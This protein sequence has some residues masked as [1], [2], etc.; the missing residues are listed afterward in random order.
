MLIGK[1]V[2]L[3]NFINKLTLKVNTNSRL[4][5]YLQVSVSKSFVK[6][7]DN[8]SGISDGLEEG[9]MSYLSDAV[10]YSA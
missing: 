7:S 8:H 10:H 4:L 2:A 1:S 3:V 5:L 9:S 6:M